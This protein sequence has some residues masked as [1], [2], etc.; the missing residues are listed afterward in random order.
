MSRILAGLLLILSLVLPARAELLPLASPGGAERFTRAA[1]GP[2]A[3]SMLVNLETE[4]YLTF[5]GPASLATALNS[6]GIHEPTPAVFHPHRRVTQE[7]LFTAENLL[8]R[9]YSDVQIAGLTLEQ[10]G[11]FA[12]NLGTE[13]V[14][15]HAD[16]M[17]V[18]GL[19][20]RIRTAMAEPSSRVVLNYLR[21][22]L[23]QVGEGHVSPAAAFDAASDSV[24][25]LDVARYK[26]P[27]VWVPLPL[28]HQAMLPPD[29]ASGRPRGLLVLTTRS[30]P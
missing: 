1:A 9:S 20:A 25:I 8:V 24:L 21:S 3:L 11:Q 17:D 2:A 26:Y 15:T 5:C 12:R 28:L 27:P 14:A 18:D 13:A 22:A 10:L 29:A 6:L 16:A 30:R 23:G 7:S 19:R 4:M